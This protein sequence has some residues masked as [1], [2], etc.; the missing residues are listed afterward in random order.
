MNRTKEE[1]SAILFYYTAMRPV[2]IHTDR[3]ADDRL[4]LQQVSDGNIQAYVQLFEKYLPLLS[5]FLFPFATQYK[6]E[7]E[8]IIQDIFLKIWEKRETLIAIRSFDRYLFR[9][10]K[11][12]VIDLLRRQQAKRRFQERYAEMKDPATPATGPEDL[13]QYAHYN[14]TA[15]KAI[16]NLTPKLREVFA[17]STEKDLSL[18]EIA[19]KLSISKDAV[20]KRLYTAN[21]AIKN[22]L[23][24]HGEWLG[25]M[26][27][28]LVLWLKS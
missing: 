14:T 27:I 28:F 3:L 22:Y 13:L 12:R 5:N 19:E 17:L 2:Y 4:L 24:E 20:K 21:V 7:T 9:M 11:T 26:G 8:D 1:V 6:V 23:K 15:Q 25:V 16:D 10:A 18:D